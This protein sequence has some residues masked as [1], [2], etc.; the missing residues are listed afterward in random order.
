VSRDN[1]Q[2]STARVFQIVAYQQSVAN[3][4]ANCCTL[5]ISCGLLLFLGHVIAQVMQCW[6]NQDA[7]A[8]LQGAVCH[9]VQH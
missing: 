9:D 6:H 5:S 7:L 8:L 1:L 2:G 3:S 4:F